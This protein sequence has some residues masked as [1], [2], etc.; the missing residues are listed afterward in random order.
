MKQTNCH[1]IIS[2]PTFSSQLHSIQSQF[3]DENYALT[4]DD[5]PAFQTIFPTIF[6]PSNGEDVEPYPAG[7]PAQMEDVTFFLHSS[8]STGFPKPIQQRHIDMLHFAN[9]RES[10]SQCRLTE[11]LIFLNKC[12]QLRRKPVIE[13]SHGLSCPVRRIMPWVLS[14]NFFVPLSLGFQLGFSHPQLTHRRPS[15]HRKIRFGP[16]ALSGAMR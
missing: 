6:S 15:L 1:R 9:T 10:F 2:Q 3:T 5:L 11:C 16:V 7:S 4:V 8:G 14:C 13:T 12:Q